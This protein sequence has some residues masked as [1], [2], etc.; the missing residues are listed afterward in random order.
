MT[1]SKSRG[2]KED[3]AYCNR[4]YHDN[5]KTSESSTK[6]PV[7]PKKMEVFTIDDGRE[8][9]DNEPIERAG[10]CSRNMGTIQTGIGNLYEK[11]NDAIHIMIYAILLILYGCYFSYAMYYSFGDEGSVRLLWVTCVVVFFSIIA[12]MNANFGERMYKSCIGPAERFFKYD[13]VGKKILKVTKVIVL[14]IILVLV[15]V[16]LVLDVALK[17][18][19]NL[20]SLAGLAAY[21]LL[22]YI[23]SFS[24]AA[25]KWQ[26][27]IG[28]LLLQFVFALIILRTTAG[29]QAFEWLGQRVSEFLEHTDAGSK[30]VFGDDYTEHFFAFKVLPVVVFFSTIISVLYYLGWMQVVIKKVAWVM[31]TFMGTTA[32]ESLNA[33]G[34]IFIG[35]SEAP[36]MIRPLI[37]N[38]TKSEIHAVMTGG[39]ATIAGSV[40]AAYINF[41][42]PANHLLSASVMSAPAALAMAKLFYPETEKSKT[43]SKDVATIEKSPERNIIEAAS[44]GASQSIRL[45][46]NIT[47]NLI[48]FLAILQFIDSTLIWVGARVGVDEPPLSFKLICSYLF[49]P[50][51]V[52]MGADIED[53]GKLAGL[54]GLKTFTNEFIAYSELGTLISNKETLDNYTSFYNTNSSDPNA[55]TTIN[56]GNLYLIYTGITLAGGVIKKRTEIIATYALCGFA[57]LGSMG[58]M[59]GALSAMAPHKQSDIAAVAVRAMIAGNVACFMTACIAGLLYQ[60]SLE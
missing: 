27:V 44:T 40:L 48:A 49:W 58:I 24:P 51:S 20:V 59:I 25:V 29:F 32:G 6:E 37:Q 10:C 38:M 23:F 55:V 5:E 26:P 19:I 47:V 46:A 28:G 39:F 4:G 45:V 60:P 17:H 53:C 7:S 34:N 50:L 41:G 21:I 11:Y 57:N 15:V 22:F 56:N 31:Q 18:P 2:N 35:Q 16:F 12:V 1:I 30:F 54:I 13:V 33:A 52:L 14:L 36:L 9:E 3:G 43:T 42:V 8:V